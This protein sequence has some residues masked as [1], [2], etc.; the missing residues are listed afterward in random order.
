MQ[1]NYKFFENKKECKYYPCH[2]N[3]KEINCLFCFCPLY[4]TTECQDKD[5]KYTLIW[6]Y[7]CKH[8]TFPHIRKNYDTIVKRL[9]GKNE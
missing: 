6:D 1:N 5:F 7:S 2:K 4:R 8:C 9:R 3:L